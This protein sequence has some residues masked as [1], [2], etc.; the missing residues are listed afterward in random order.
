MSIYIAVVN[1]QQNHMQLNQYDAIT[2]F[3]IKTIYEEKNTRY[4][5]PQTPLYFLNS[6][7]D[8]FLWLSRKD[9]WNHFYHFNRFGKLIGQLTRGL[10]E[11]TEYLGTD[12][13]DEFLNFSAS[14][15][16]PLEKH[17]YT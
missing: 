2:G 4:V 16:T 8:E 13:K 14:I 3:F 15:D 12:P 11:V 9:G 6:N 10:W 17:I 5:E 7:S 1:R